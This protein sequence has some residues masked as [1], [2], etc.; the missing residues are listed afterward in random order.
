[1]P[2][3]PGTPDP[4]ESELAILQVLWRKGPSS[5]REVWGELGQKSG[6][7]TVLKF[8]QIMLEKGL[9]RRDETKL[10][11]IY[12]AAVAKNITQERLVAGLMDRAFGGSTSQL[13]LR[14]LAAKPV[15][16]EELRAIRALLPKEK[17]DRR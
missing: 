8:L 14:A 9:V 15:S 6:Y 7:T 3:E 13:V 2:A 4:T 5:V 11:H 12:K 1:M 17:V 16:A 10:T